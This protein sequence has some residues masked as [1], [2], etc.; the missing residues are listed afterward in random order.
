MVVLTAMSC[1]AVLCPL[2]VAA[3]YTKVDGL[4]HEKALSLG[5]PRTQKKSCIVHEQL[6]CT[7]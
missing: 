1:H 7:T 5:L 6:H 2:E 4:E 3:I